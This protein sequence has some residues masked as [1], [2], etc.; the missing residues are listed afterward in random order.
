MKTN[1][2]SAPI[3]RTIWTSLASWLLAAGLAQGA[4]TVIPTNAVW[5]YLND[6]SNQ[7]AAWQLVGFNDAGWASGPAELGYGD[8]G[9]PEFRPEATV[10]P[11][12]PNPN[13]KPI[14]TYFRHTFNLSSVASLTNVQVR[15]LRAIERLCRVTD[16]RA[17]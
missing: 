3:I 12:G 14:T 1:F 15:L 17:G 5:R 4:I 7:G 13:N 11:F 2:I 8:A 16:G 6:G 9:S 10:V